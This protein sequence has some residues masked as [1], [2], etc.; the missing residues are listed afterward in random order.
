MSKFS[1]AEFRRQLALMFIRLAEKVEQDE[2]LAASLFEGTIF[3]LEAPKS[4]VKPKRKKRE[5][6]EP[7]DAIVSVEAAPN[8]L[9]LSELYNI[10]LTEGPD[11]L[12][13]RLNEYELEQ[14]REIVIRD[15]MDPARKVRRW[16]T[17]NKVVGAIVEVVGKQLAKG[18]AFAK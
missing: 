5:P 16:K 8:L 12:R 15:G 10:H 17:K 1:D 14:L 13:G 3:D 4:E 11:T 9:S 6:K 2:Q 18:S 7:N